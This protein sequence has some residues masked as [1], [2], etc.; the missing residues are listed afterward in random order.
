[1]TSFA[2]FPEP[3]AMEM[4]A[5]M[6]R[7]EGASKFTVEE[8]SKKLD[9][10]YNKRTNMRAKRAVFFSV[11]QKPAD[12]LV[13]IANAL[14]NQCVKCNYPDSIL[15]D[16]L[17]SAFT[18]GLENEST[19]RYIWPLPESSLEKFDALFELALK[20]ES[21]REDAKHAGANSVDVAVVKRGNFRGRGEEGVAVEVK[22]DSKV[23]KEEPEL[24]SGLEQQII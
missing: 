7:P 19:R 4:L 10:A 21:S 13:E 17:S 16:Q 5:S 6:C 24:V 3:E 2:G 18:A 15:D 22:K 20:F 14:R 23:P 1:M 9:I 11:K 12:S 8:L